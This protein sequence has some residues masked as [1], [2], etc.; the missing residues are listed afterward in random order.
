MLWAIPLWISLYSSEFLAET[1]AAMWLNG[2]FI[3]A[4]NV[5]MMGLC[6]GEWTVVLWLNALLSTTQSHRINGIYCLRKK[7]RSGFRRKFF[8]P[9]RFTSRE[10]TNSSPEVLNSR[11][12]CYNN[13]LGTKWDMNYHA[14]YY[15]NSAI[16]WKSFKVGCGALIPF[17][18]PSPLFYRA[19]LRNNYSPILTLFWTSYG[20]SHSVEVLGFQHPFRNWVKCLILKA[21]GRPR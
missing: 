20:W 2:T 16:D 3:L 17:I 18:Y 7:R 8:Y 6:T 15:Y 1:I 5:K 21:H 19:F 12:D 11:N 9:S 4:L 14:H 10:D 13:N